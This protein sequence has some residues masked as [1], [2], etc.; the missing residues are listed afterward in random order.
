MV[1]AMDWFMAHVLE[2]IVHP[3]HIPLETKSQST[4]VGRTRDSRPGRRFFGDGHDSRETLVANGVKVFHEFDGIEILATAMNI[5]YPFARFPGV[6]KV[7]HG[8][9]GI[10]SQAVD[11]VFVE[12]EKSVGDQEVSYFIAPEIKNSGAPVFVLA[13]ARVF[14]IVKIRASNFARPWASLGKCAGTQSSI[15]PRLC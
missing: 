9:N 7:E 5:G 6:V 4:Q 13:P 14:V 1:A 3:T 2:K 12:P 10:H 15:T 11:M 8:S